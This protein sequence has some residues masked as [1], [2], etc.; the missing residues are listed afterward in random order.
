VY[1]KSRGG[2]TL[3]AGHYHSR[4]GKHFDGVIEIDIVEN[5]ARRA[6][7]KLKVQAL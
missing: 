6:A 1:D 7:A 2:N 5:Y 3:L 4:L